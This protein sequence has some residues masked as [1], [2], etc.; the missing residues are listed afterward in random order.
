MLVS[1][2]DEDLVFIN[3]P[4]DENYSELLRAIVF[5]VYKCKLFPVTALT[6][7]NALENR[8]DKIIKLIK[9]CKYGIHDI[10]RISLNQN[11][12]PRFNMPFELGIFFG[13][14]KF[15]NNTQKKKVALVFEETKYSY[16]QIISD[17]NGIDTKAHSSNTE[18]LIRELRNW[19][20]I[21]KLNQEIPL[22]S[23]ITLE[24]N[25]LN[26]YLPEMS[27]NDFCKG[28]EVYLERNATH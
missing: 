22:A 5:T 21:Q 14:S 3:C 17:L 25:E 12:Y 1:H 6:E 2:K 10:S 13:A 23:E 15:G 7:D 20:K 19:I 18:K 26:T 4:F 27:F 28:V 16:Q 24:F 9:K 8:L 11:G